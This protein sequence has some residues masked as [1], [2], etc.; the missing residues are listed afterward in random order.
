MRLDKNMNTN[1]TIQKYVALCRNH[2]VDIHIA[3]SHGDS[4]KQKIEETTITLNADI[5]PESEFEAYLAYNVRKVLVPQLVLTTERLILRRFQQTD[6]KDCFGFLGDKQCCYNDG[7]YE[8]F[9]EMD[10]EYY[11]LMDR[12]ANQPM[13]KM[14]ALQSTDK[15]I[16]TVNLMEANDRVVGTYEIGYVI[17][18]D[19]QRKGYAF[20][21]VSAL[22][23]SLFDELH[24]DMFIAGAIEN[25]QTSHRLLNKLGFQYKGRKTK[26]FYHPEYGA[27]DL[28]YY[29]KER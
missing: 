20:E 3:L 9:D 24:L 19:Y 29:V 11:A 25:N 23:R 16:G 14:I 28:L 7:G 1:D 27:T 18:P 15:V 8:P 13:R 6:A 26:S 2:G 22:C 17:S 10:E 12:F 21:A 4:C 5:I